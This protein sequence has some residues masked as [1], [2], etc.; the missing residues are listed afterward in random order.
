MVLLLTILSVLAA[1]A[2]L[3]LLVIG[4]LLI[5]KALESVRAF[6]QK[7]TMGVRA[8]EQQTAPLGAH[9]DALTASLKEADGALCAAATR[10]ADVDRGL[11]AAAPTLRSR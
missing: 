10:L 8:I 2:F 9:T 6:L 11:R 3:M 5:L 7:I 1:W 4:L